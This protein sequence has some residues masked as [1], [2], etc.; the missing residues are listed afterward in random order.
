MRV[1]WPKFQVVD[2]KRA[3]PYTLV[4]TMWAGKLFKNR[5]FN[6]LPAVA[7]GWSLLCSGTRDRP[8][9]IMRGAGTWFCIWCLYHIEGEGTTYSNPTCRKESTEMLSRH[10]SGTSPAPSPPQKPLPSLLSLTLRHEEG[11]RC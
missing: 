9:R 3:S 5:I 8:K 4:E 11:G 1:S 2:W 6:S 7:Q 10:F